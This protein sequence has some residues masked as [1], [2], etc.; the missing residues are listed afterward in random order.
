MALD[1]DEIKNWSKFLSI[2]ASLIIIALGIARFCN[3]FNVM[4]PID[5]II[6]VYLMY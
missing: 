1:Y 4:D 2:V 6:N 3:V 5:Y